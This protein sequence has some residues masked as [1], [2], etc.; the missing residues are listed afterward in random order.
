[1]PESNFTLI[2]TRH[3]ETRMS[4]RGVRREDIELTLI[5]GTHIP[6]D[7]WFMTHADADPE[8]AALKRRIKQMMH[9]TTSRS[10]QWFREISDLKHMIQQF[11]RLKKKNL[12]VVVEGGTVVTCY[13]SC[14][15][16]QK[17]TLRRGRER[18]A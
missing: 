2:L 16:D 17:R 12:K 9:G 15:A 6:P 7:T 10:R 11:E 8:I 1:M 3:A 4:Q 5:F 13:P 18:A 14:T